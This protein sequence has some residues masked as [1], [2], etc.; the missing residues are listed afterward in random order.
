MYMYAYIL[1][2]YVY[3]LYICAYIV[4]MCLCMYVYMNIG[5]CVE[6]FI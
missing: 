3:M 5:R 6:D 4:C 2:K 1:C